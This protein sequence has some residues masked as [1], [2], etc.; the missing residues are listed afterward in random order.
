[1]RDYYYNYYYYYYYHYYYYLLLLLLLLLLL[2][3]YYYHHWYYTGMRERYTVYGYVIPV[4]ESA[5]TRYTRDMG[6][7]SVIY[8]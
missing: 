6:D 5:Y 3:Y 7:L 4:C 2:Q 8:V 1:M